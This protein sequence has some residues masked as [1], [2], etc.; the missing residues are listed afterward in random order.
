MD[1]EIIAAIVGPA[2][3]AMLAGAAVGAKNWWNRRNQ[4][5]QRDRAI[6]QASRQV[7]FIDA[8]LSA[9]GKAAGPEQQAR[10]LR[11]ISDLERAYEAMT[12][13]VTA[14]RTSS[15]RGTAGEVARTLL[16][17]PLH[18]TRAKVA[19]A[20]Y[21]LFLGVGFLFVLATIDTIAEETESSLLKNIAIGMIV[22]V[23]WFLP[24]GI[25]WPVTRVLDREKTAPQ[26]PPPLG[27]A[28]NPI[29]T[30]PP[31]GY[32]PPSWPQVTDK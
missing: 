14:E 28:Y 1:P 3:T 4:T 16:L 30:Q 9:Y 15:G 17:V 20:L 8:W 21:Y 24:A 6:E 26:S 27:Y 5:D 31:A 13:A 2:L 12:T 22:T 32:P 23:F 29:P 11:A 7:A 25:M 19:R 10:R 18:R